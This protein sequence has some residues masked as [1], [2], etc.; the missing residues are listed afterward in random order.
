MNAMPLALS[1]LAL[2]C[3]T[4]T[5]PE[6]PAPPPDPAV[7]EAAGEDHEH[8]HDHQQDHHHSAQAEQ[9]HAHGD[10]ATVGHG[11]DDVEKW[12]AIF[13]DPTRA[14]WQKPAELVAALG[15]TPGMVVADLGAGT[16]Y[17]NAALAAAV[18]A[19]GEVIAQDIEPNM[20]EH[21]KARAVT[22]E[23]PQVDVRLATA[24]ET[25]FAA[26]ELDLALVVN[27]YH[28]IGDRVAYF[29]GLKA[30]LKEGGRLAIVEFKPEETPVGPPVAL[31]LAPQTVREE[32]V[33]A[34]W[35]ERE[36]LD[37]LPYQYVLVFT[38]GE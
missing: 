1:A 32:L 20:V 30:A 33:A 29:T 3:G 25:G 22:E 36:A 11:F 2:A 15:V 5:P 34:G 14:E 26:G 17:F 16:G 4:P 37:L 8:A 31:R 13:D 9:A 38:P 27:T 18:G 24:E 12:A 19:E 28:H 35:T 21:M 7:I 10:H 23:T 6:Q